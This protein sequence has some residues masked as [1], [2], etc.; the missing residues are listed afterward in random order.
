[1]NDV[2]ELP[3][4]WT[5]TTLGEIL[6]DPKKDLVDGPFGSNLKSSEYLSLKYRTSKRTVLLIKKLIL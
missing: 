3:K 1:M 5:T 4:G 2:K 6:L